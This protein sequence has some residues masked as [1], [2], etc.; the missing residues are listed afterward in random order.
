[1]SAKL[2][3][4][5]PGS[6]LFGH[7][8][9]LKGDVLGFYAKSA[10]ECG[11]VA[12]LRFGLKHVW[13]VSHPDLIAEVLSSRDFTKHYALRMNRMLLGDGLL[14]S[15]GD[16]WLRQ[17]RLIQ[18]PFLRARVLKHGAA[19]VELAEQR[20][21]SWRDGESRDLHAE[22]RGLTMG[23][24]ARTLFGAEV[25]S[26]DGAEVAAALEGATAAFSDRL[27]SVLRL[28][29]WF[30]I[31][32][33]VRSW[34]AIR[35]LDRI[36]Y[37]IIARSRRDGPGDDLLSI[38]LHARDEH[39]SGMTEKQLRDE[40]MTLFLAG[41]E[42]TALAL[43]YAL[44]LLAR[45][46][47][48][49]AKLREEIDALGAPPT[50]DDLPRLRYAEQVAL[51]AMRL[52][53]PA[54]AI[55]RQSVAACRL[56]DYVLPRGGTVLMSQW[57]AHRDPRWW[58]APEEFRPERWTAAMQEALPRHAYFPFGG[59]PRVCVGNT[60]AMVELVLV[61]AVL[62]RWRYEALEPLR[63]RP[64]ITLGHEGP[65]RMVVRR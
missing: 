36:L 8:S 20:V 29:E 32:S 30:P 15:E 35:R 28:P 27:F 51:E 41:H 60:F 2:P 59:G 23:I 39:G 13:L 12:L 49:A 7:L 24:A 9:H 16:F 40:A 55:G 50:V 37:S 43:T 62:G 52:Y 6:F 56:G 18:P 10:R 14:S 21:A 5:L 47:D 1:M 63:F 3:P 64:R 61:L 22:M 34:Y 25:G 45:H 33:N 31:P 57:V 53:P 54:Y 38:L 48:K 65:V 17:R 11:D 19:F 46:P 44:H 58:D 26:S 42:T 4:S